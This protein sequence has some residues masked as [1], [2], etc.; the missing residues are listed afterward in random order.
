MHLQFKDNHDNGFFN[1]SDFSCSNVNELINKKDNYRIVWV[2]EGTAKFVVDSVPYTLTK[3]QVIFFTPLNKIEIFFESDNVISFSFNEEFYCVDNTNSEVSCHGYLFFGSSEVPVITLEEKEQESFGTLYKV[4]LEEF[5]N[6][7]HIQGEMLRM[8]LKRLLIKSMRLVQVNLVNPSIS[9]SQLDVVRQYNMLVEMNF[10][11]MHQVK[12]YA[13]L[14]YKSPK[15]LSNLFAQ[16]NDR[17]PLQV[18]N[19]RIALEA[20]RLLIY[21]SKTVEEISYELGYKDASHFSK[22][23]KK[24]I[25]SSPKDFKSTSVVT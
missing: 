24:Q 14:L 21:S 25:G 7:D 2:R 13:D 5:E 6:K 12:E 22:F 17:T 4:M 19:D 20:K 23:F 11:E 18:I 3:N 9:Q 16:Y 10:R 15:T 8:L 1:I